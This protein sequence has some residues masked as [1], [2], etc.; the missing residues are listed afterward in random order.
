M[1]RNFNGMDYLENDHGGNGH[2]LEKILG[3]NII[4][5]SANIN[6]LGLPIYAK[7]ILRDSIKEIL[8]YPDPNYDLLLKKISNKINIPMDNILLGN[9]SVDL[10]YLIASVINPKRTQ[11]TVPT[12][13]EY[14]KAAI[15]SGSEIFYQL[16]YEK[17]NFDFYKESKKEFNMEFYCNPNNP[18]GNFLFNNKENINRNSNCIYVIDEA[19]MEF[20]DRETEFSML[21]KAIRSNNIIV[22]RAFT[23]IYAIPGLRIGYLV[24]NRSIVRKLK[25]KMPP[26]SIN[27]I[28]Q[29]LTMRMLDDVKYVE[30]TRNLIC[31]ERDRLQLKLSEIKG[32]KTFLSEANWLLVKLEKNKISA[33]TLKKRL[34]ERGLLIRSCGNFKGLGDRFFRIAIRKRKENNILLKNLMD[35][36]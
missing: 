23:K 30:D 36:L 33:L 18:T 31:E 7:E 22:L 24:A 8:K 12:F 11:I 29:N 21:Q 32:I 20:S 27:V 25:Q 28:A 5:F 9:G 1:F 19:F 10:I 6:P 13:S 34:L 14:E 16:L 4:D 2:V 15:N 35:I 17:E 3:K 26:W